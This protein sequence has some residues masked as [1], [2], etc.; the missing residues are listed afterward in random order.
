MALILTNRYFN[1]DAEAGTQME[2]I[3]ASVQPSDRADFTRVQAQIRSSYHAAL[4]QR[5]K[6]E[7]LAHL[8]STRP[9]GSLSPAA[10]SNPESTLAR[11]ERKERLDRFLQ[12]WSTHAGTKPFFTGLYAILRLQGLPTSLG[13]AGEMR[14][15]WEVDDA[16]FRESA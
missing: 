2:K 15:E 12:T 14:M 6:Q 13:G 5:R 3:L 7:Y 1:Q 9:G 10:R 8:S 16:V 4:A 11:E